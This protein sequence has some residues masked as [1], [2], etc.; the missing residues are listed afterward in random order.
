LLISCPVRFPCYVQHFGAGSCH[1]STV[2]WNV[3]GFEPL[4]FLSICS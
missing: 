4:I 2:F 1:I 3:L